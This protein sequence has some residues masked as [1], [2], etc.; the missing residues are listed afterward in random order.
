MYHPPR[1]HD[2]KLLEFCNTEKQRFLYSKILETGSC[3]KGAIAAGYSSRGAR[4]LVERLIKFAAARGYS[5]A[6]DLTH[7]TPSTHILK[8]TSTL[9]NAEG[10]ITQQW[11]KTNIAEQERLETL[12]EACKVLAEPYKGLAVPC[13]RTKDKSDVRNNRTTEKELLGLLPY[14]DP[15]LGLYSWHKETGSDFDC[16]IAE[17][18]LVGVTQE[19]VRKMPVC[20][21]AI[22]LNLGDFFHSDSNANQTLRSHHAL[23]V[24]SRWARVMQIGIQAMR[25]CID[26][27]LKK[28][29]KVIV[30]NM[31]GN[32]DDHSSVMLAK[33]LEAFYWKEK[34][35]T[36]WE[37]NSKFWYYRHGKVLLGSTHG[38]TLKPTNM[39]GIMAHDA[40]KDW[41]L[42]IHRHVHTGHVHQKQIWELHGCTV[43]SHRTLAARDSWAHAAGYRSARDMQ[44][45]IYHA[46]LGET[47]RYRV[48][49]Q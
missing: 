38:D 18:N 12:T 15:H 37:N 32:H 23:D 35:V 28:H 9:Y 40:A 42:S 26:A 21:T 49:V 45:I 27:A 43:E 10:Q 8:G 29:G 14:G 7:P 6:H 24:D 4:E 41:G 19:L 13:S 36:V 30:V 25:S 3:T 34:R 47:E 2:P 48:G 20:D 44:A 16:D 46:E 39:A 17:R 31:V 33:V 1:V 11:V 22:L 5:P